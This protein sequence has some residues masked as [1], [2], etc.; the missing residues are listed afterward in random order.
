MYE[1]RLKFVKLTLFGIYLFVMISLF[2]KISHDIAQ[3]NFHNGSYNCD[4]K[5][6]EECFITIHNFVKF[7]STAIM[8]KYPGTNDDVNWKTNQN[9]KTYIYSY[10]RPFLIELIQNSTQ[11]CLCCV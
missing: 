7:N 6:P 4:V 8:K 10:T 1:E 5:R 9:F 11:D 2:F 3:I